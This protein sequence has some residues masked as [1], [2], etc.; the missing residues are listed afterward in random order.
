MMMIYRLKFVTYKKTKE[1]IDNIN[2]FSDSLK[3]LNF[4]LLKDSLAALEQSMEP[5]YIS[6]LKDSIDDFLQKLNVKK[7]GITTT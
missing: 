3:K 4:D 1:S 2:S 7:Y 5:S 6:N